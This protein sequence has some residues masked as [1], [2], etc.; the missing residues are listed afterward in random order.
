MQNKG[1]SRIASPRGGA[2]R[3]GFRLSRRPFLFI[4]S[5][6]TQNPAACTTNADRHDRERRITRAE[7][8]VIKGELSLLR[9][10]CES[11]NRSVAVAAAQRLKI[12]EAELR[13][14]TGN[15]I[16]RTCQSSRP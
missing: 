14:I 1:P 10:L 6:Q 7:V 12:R 13:K 11:P 2:R 5:M 16:Q 3:Q 8:E 15:P 9:C 4:N